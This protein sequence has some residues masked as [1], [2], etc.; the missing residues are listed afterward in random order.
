MTLS[1]VI[2][3][4]EGTSADTKVLA[5]LL[6][7]KDRCV[8]A[9][10]ARTNDLDLDVHRVDGAIEA[11]ELGDEPDFALVDWLVRVGADDAAGDCAAETDD[12]AE[13]IDYSA[14]TLSAHLHRFKSRTT[15]KEV[16]YS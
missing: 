16:T 6:I 3:I 10:Q 12:A 7:V 13:G 14:T 5:F 9:R 8:W 2:T 15:T 11:T 1:F 4:W